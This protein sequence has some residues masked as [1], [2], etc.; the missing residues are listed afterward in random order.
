[1]KNRRP[2]P[3]RDCESGQAGSGAHPDLRIRPLEARP[4]YPDGRKFPPSTHDD[5]EVPTP[6]GIQQPRGTT[7]WGNGTP[8]FDGCQEGTGI[9]EQ[10]HMDRPSL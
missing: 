8:P 10:P 7:I 4:Y 3:T 9:M 2:C 6:E 5:P 1:M